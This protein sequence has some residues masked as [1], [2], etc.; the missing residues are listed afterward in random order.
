MYCLQVNLTTGKV[1][2]ALFR[3]MD[4]VS[5]FGLAAV[6]AGPSVMPASAVLAAAAPARKSSKK[7]R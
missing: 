4:V 6:S 7:G 2:P 1:G 5:G 3:S